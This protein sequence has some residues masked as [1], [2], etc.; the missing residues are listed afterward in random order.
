MFTSDTERLDAARHWLV[1]DAVWTLLC[2]VFSAI[3]ESFSHDII[4][5]WM[6]LLFLFPL[7]GG[8]LP[9]WFF[10]KRGNVPRAFPLALWRCGVATLGVG[11]C[12]KG[13]LEIYGTTSDYQTIYWAAGTAMLAMGVLTFLRQPRKA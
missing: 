10:L 9:A 6:V 12:I 7:L 5:L 3:Y 13:V 8:V 2:A 11:S 1:A 4:S